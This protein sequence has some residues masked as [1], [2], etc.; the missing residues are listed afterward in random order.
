MLGGLVGYIYFVDSER[1]P[2]AADAKAKA[3]T[4]SRPTTSRRSQIKNAD[5][6][7]SRVQRVGDELA[8][9]RTGQGGRRRRRRRHGHQQP[10]ARSRSSASSTRT[11][12]TSRS[13][14][15]SRRAS[16]WRSVCKD[17]KDFQRLLVGEKTPTGGD[18]YAKRPNE[19]RVFLISSFLDTI[20]NKTPFDLRDKAVLKFDR[21][22]ADGIEVDRRRA[23]PSQFTRNGTEWRIVKPI[24][25]RADYAAVEGLLTR[26]SST[27]MQKIVAPEADEPEAVRPRPAGA[28]GDGH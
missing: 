7:T 22:K 25:A 28:D 13:T 12:R 4:D 18:L 5:G 19:K 23:A 9:R 24:A 11:R 1:D 8:A 21:D 16:R 27:H 15:S 2:A 14:A 10:V 17:Q 26:L 3:F 6:E 20:F